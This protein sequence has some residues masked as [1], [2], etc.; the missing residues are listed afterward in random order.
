MSI[1]EE[2]NKILE[3]KRALITIEKNRVIVHYEMEKPLV[4]QRDGEESIEVTMRRS[5]INLK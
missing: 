3:N 5:L 2:I 4:E 1:W